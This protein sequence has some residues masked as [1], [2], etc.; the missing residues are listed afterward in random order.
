MASAAATQPRLGGN[1][2]LA[3]L[4]A[5]L[6]YVPFEIVAKGTLI[7]SAFLFIVDPIPP[8]SRILAVVSLL[9]V[10]GLSKLHK[11]ALQEEEEEEQQQHN[12]QDVTVASNS[13]I[14]TTTTTTKEQSDQKKQQ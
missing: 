14:V 4:L 2:I 11:K 8:L 10:N 12:D 7:V 9:L 5:L 3:S 13:T 1:L 6:S